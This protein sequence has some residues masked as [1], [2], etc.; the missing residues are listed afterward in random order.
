MLCACDAY[1]IQLTQLIK[2]SLQKERRKWKIIENNKK[3]HKN[4]KKCNFRLNMPNFQGVLSWGFSDEY[5]KNKICAVFTMHR[6]NFLRTEN[7][8]KWKNQK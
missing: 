7:N 1:K 4:A 2:C 5:R 8:K 6:N 3:I